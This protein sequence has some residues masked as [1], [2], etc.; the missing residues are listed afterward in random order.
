MYR[1]IIVSDEDIALAKKIIKEVVWED[2][3]KPSLNLLLAE[4]VHDG[5]MSIRNNVAEE[6][7]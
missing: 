6:L 5:L 7:S 4:A 2:E 3:K 1:K